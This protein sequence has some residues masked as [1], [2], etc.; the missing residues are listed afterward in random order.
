MA[1]IESNHTMAAVRTF[2]REELVS[3]RIEKFDEGMDLIEQGVIDSLSLL[4]LVN[5]LEQSCQI[6]V[7]DEE[8]VP[9]NFRS[10]AA[11]ETFIATR[12]SAQPSEGN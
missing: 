9:D 5:F 1:T 3:G 4:R 11:I 10:L 12:Q 8:I 6:L 2:I 7:P